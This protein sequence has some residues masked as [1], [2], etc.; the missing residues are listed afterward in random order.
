M[1]QT[2]SVTGYSRNGSAKPP[3]GAREVR[4]SRFRRARRPRHLVAVP[5][6]NWP[7]GLFADDASMGELVA[8]DFPLPPHIPAA[9]RGYQNPESRPRASH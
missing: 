1:S 6:L 5:A 9:S 7:S 3:V 2:I 8:D 4:T